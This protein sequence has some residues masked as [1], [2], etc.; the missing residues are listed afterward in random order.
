[1]A[2][3]GEFSRSDGGQRQ[4]RR[5]AW[6]AR[7][8]AI[9][10]V[11]FALVALAEWK[12][13]IMAPATVAFNMLVNVDFYTQIYPMSHRAAEWIRNGVLPLWNPFQSCGLP[14]AATGIYGVFY[15]LNFPYLI[16]PT[17]LAI[18]LVDLLHTTLA[19]V[20][21]Y[22]YCRVIGFERTAA[23]LTGLVFM[24]SGY[25]MGQ[26]TWFPPAL[27]ACVWLPI[28][29]LA[30][31]QVV[32]GRR[33]RALVFALAVAMGFLAG[34]PQ[35]WVYA[36]YA[37][38]PYAA[39]RLVSVARTSPRKAAGDAAALAVGAALG[40]GLAAIQLL[41]E[42]EL[43]AL[44]PRHVGGL[45]MAKM[46]SFAVM[47]PGMLF[48]SA[49]DQTPGPPRLAY[50]GLL[51]FV[52]ATASLWAERRGRLV[53]FWILALT[54]AA[55]A[56]T[57]F[58][59]LFSI[60]LWLPGAKSFRAVPRILYLYAF[61]GAIITGY[62]FSVLTRD[63]GATSRRR[64]GSLT[65]ALTVV[66]LALSFVVGSAPARVEIAAGIVACWALLW[67]RTP[68]ARAG[69]GLALVALV[70]AD[71]VYSIK[72]PFLHPYQNES[73]FYEDRPFLDY[74]KQRQGYDRTYIHQV[75][76]LPSMMAKQ[77]TLR[78]IYSVTD[79]EPLSLSRYQGVLSRMDS[80]T[81][82]IA[83][84]KTFTGDLDA[85][86]NG[87][88]FGLLGLLSTKYVIALRA[89]DAYL[90]RLAARGY[91]AEPD[92]PSP[93]YALYRAPSF[94]PRTFVARRELRVTNER[95]ALDAISAPDFDGLN[96]AVLEGL[97]A[98]TRRDLPVAAAG[99][100]S[101]AKIT[102]YT[103]TRVVVTT[104][105]AAPGWLVLTDTN[106]PGWVADIDGTPSP[107]YRADSLF[108]SVFL[109]PGHHRVTFF[110]RATSFLVGAAITFLTALIIAGYFA[111]RRFS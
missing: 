110:Y 102:E 64:R 92:A 65:A 57:F 6:P 26:A 84:L 106:Y 90:Q 32:A 108:R 10:A 22:A 81:G 82:P 104:D 45:S 111:V 100:A 49:I 58:T 91:T 48:A 56:L 50:L 52:L 2:R 47:S 93:R 11:G 46:L 17:G 13:R 28:E 85:D 77:G 61:A 18:E 86:P 74:V 54:S 98:T 69:A 37:V 95:E 31:E 89:D 101:T 1:V 66:G 42:L 109:T 107:I 20:A 29:L 75:W 9:V 94:L 76:D 3:S 53:Y 4:R 38:I 24:L 83:A 67:L 63:P 59:P 78:G 19:G 88:N 34:W 35:V 30:V 25:V 21:M 97:D 71:L 39:I 60:F 99:P 15:P 7:E 68:L 12:T 51:A 96:T 72:N 16:A 44:G 103:P 105:V 33:S 23:A 27:A 80:S 5:S 55:V 41:P 62:G 43:H 40:I 14:F 8:L 73:V 70:G 36:W 87:K 79:Y